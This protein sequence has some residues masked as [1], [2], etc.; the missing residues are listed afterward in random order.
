MKKVGA[1]Q[2]DDRIS[3][4]QLQFQKQDIGH[5]LCH[6]IRVLCNRAVIEIVD[7]EIKQ[8]L[9]QDGK[10]EEGEIHPV[11]LSAHHVLNG[12]VYTENPERFNQQVDKN[13]KG[14]IGVKRF[15]HLLPA[16]YANS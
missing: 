15:F 14:E 9:K 16:K 6:K 8:N 13:E 10:I 1:K 2:C 11:R 3:S 5:I 4:C 7:S 12:T